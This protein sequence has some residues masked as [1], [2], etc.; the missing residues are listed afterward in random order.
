MIKYIGKNGKHQK[1]IKYRKPLIKHRSSQRAHPLIVK[2][3]NSL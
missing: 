3:G 1:E 2:N